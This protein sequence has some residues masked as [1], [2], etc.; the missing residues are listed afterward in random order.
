MDIY[1]Y[2]PF[3]LTIS[4]FLIVWGARRTSGDMLQR[5]FV[6]INPL[7]GKS[8]DEIIETVGLPNSFVLN[9]KTW[10]R[11]GFNI[12]LSFDNDNICTGVVSQLRF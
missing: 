12:T 4:I 8:Y 5:K 7:K 3:L 2:G 6:S 11:G 1:F 10:S 9:H